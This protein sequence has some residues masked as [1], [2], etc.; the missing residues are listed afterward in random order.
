[1]FDVLLFIYLSW[2]NDLYMLSSFSS[3]NSVL[4]YLTCCVWII[5]LK[6]YTKWEMMISS[7]YLC[8]IS[9]W[10]NVPCISNYTVITFEDRS[11]PVNLRYFL[12]FNSNVASHLLLFALG[13][14]HVKSLLFVCF[15]EDITYQLQ[16][17]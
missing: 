8:L 11:R 6:Y 13:L 12:S 16:L 3:F 15:S 14:L 4:L 7:D 10:C 9:I 17:R 1:M 2:S 5:I